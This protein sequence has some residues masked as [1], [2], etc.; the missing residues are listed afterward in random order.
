MNDFV[1]DR[2]KYAC[3][4]L[5]LAL[6]HTPANAAEGRECVVLLHGLL[7]SSASMDEMAQALGKAGYATA[8]IDYSTRAGPIRELA[9]QA[10]PEGL[11]AC[12]G[13]DEIHF[14]AHS[15]GGILLRQYAARHGGEG[16]GRVVMLGPPNQGTEAVN[17]LLEVPGMAYLLGPAGR[18]LGT[19][20]DYLP[21]RLPPVDFETGIIAGTQAFNLLLS[22]L[23]ADPDDG[24]VSVRNTEVAGMCAHVAMDVTHF[25][26]MYNE[27]V[28]AQTLHFLRHGEFSLPR[29][30]NGLCS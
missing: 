19:G 9:E 4:L 26:M 3:M 30:R 29:A 16:I 14:V 8:N 21:A 11:K 18:E 24:T 27:E 17:K 15:M 28:I 22:L 25:L 5:I 13:A 10:V 20:K 1:R 6:C 2:M 23:V 7:R 12:R